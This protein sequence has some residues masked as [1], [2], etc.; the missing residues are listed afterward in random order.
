MVSFDQA[1]HK[2]LDIAMNLSF[3]QLQDSMFV[4][5]ATRIIEQSGVDASRLEFELTE[6]AILS[7]F[8]Q[9]Y[10]GMQALSK[11]GISFSLDD[12]GT[13]FSSFSH[14]QR[15]PISALK[16]DRSFI[17]N[18]MENSEDA[19]IVKS[20]INLARSLSLKIIAEGVETLDQVQLLWQCL[21]DQVQGFY[22]SP[23]VSA[24]DL[25]LMVDQRAMAA[26]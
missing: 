18:V 1:G 22:F 25:C 23:A 9:T 8:Q 20:M 2:H 16:I 24:K 14:I 19:I 21:C 6:T 3:K 12:F 7:N 15:L 10:E 11:L 26:V 4:E 5:T 13:G 17:R